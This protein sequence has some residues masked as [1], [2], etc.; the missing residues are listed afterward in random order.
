MTTVVWK[1]NQII[2]NVDW[3]IRMPP[4]LWSP[5]TDIFEVVT[6][7]IV[8]VEVAGMHNQDFIIQLQDNFLIIS[9]N[10]TDTSERR[11]YHQM[12]VR[13]GQF[14]TIVAIPGP[15]EFDNAS[16]EYI[17]GFLIVI[18]PKQ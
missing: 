3:P 17:D 15:V 1:S 2:G 5:P 4:H 6:S 13:F 7:F 16:A 10:R 14:S 12:E 18:L 9:G 11:A 8:R